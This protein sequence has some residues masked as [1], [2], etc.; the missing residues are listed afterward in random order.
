[1]AKDRIKL[2]KEALTK[3]VVKMYESGIPL[4]KALAMDGLG[5]GKS[6][7]SSTYSPTFSKEK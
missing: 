3:E 6:Y 4:H 2:P 7:A 5:N 1:M